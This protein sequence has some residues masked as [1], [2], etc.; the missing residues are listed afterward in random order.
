MTNLL[1]HGDAIHLLYLVVGP[2][3]HMFVLP[4]G[5]LVHYCHS[6][7]ATEQH[8]RQAH[9]ALSKQV[10]R[11]TLLPTPTPIPLSCG[12]APLACVCT[13]SCIETC[14]DQGGY[15]L[16]DLYAAPAPL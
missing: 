4:A 6:A 1:R 3:E 5:R 15:L 14:P 10:R 16:V 7:Y 13:A 11:R 9:A 12:L 2:S 8:V